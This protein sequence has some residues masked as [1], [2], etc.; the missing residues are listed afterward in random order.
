M[1][2]RLSVSALLLSACASSAGAAACGSSADG[3]AVWLDDFKKEAAAEGVPDRTLD[4]ALTGVVYDRAIIARDRSQK[5][6]RLSFE[7][8]SARLVTPARLA[9]GQALMQR[10][11][12]LLRQ[13][14]ARYGVP[15][16]VIIA[17]WGLETGYGADNGNFRTMQA[18]ATLAYDCRRS[19]QFNDEL[20]DALRIVQRGDMTPAQMRG[21]WAGEIGQTQFMPSSYL[22]YAVDFDGD[23]RRDLIRSPADALASTANF[24]K[25]NGWRSGAGWDEG[26]PNY[27][28]FL[29]WNKAQ[30]YAKTIAYFATKLDE[31]R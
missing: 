23:G 27:A 4:S 30:V 15:G 18:L 11:A 3:F 1:S 5:V 13:I 17:I 26:A 14:E 7:K 25:G 28:V 19:A 29:E 21:D 8:F 9:R 22:K 10:Y 12:G 6:F 20:K 31:Q 2:F 24:L 16:P